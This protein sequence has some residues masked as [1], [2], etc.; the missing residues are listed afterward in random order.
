MALLFFDGFDM[1]QATSQLAHR[2]WTNLPSGVNQPG[3]FGTSRSIYMNGAANYVIRSLAATSTISIGVAFRCETM[4]GL[5]ATGSDVFRF[6]NGTTLQCKMGVKND[7]SL[8]IGRADFVGNLIAAS[9]VGLVTAASWNYVEVELTRDAAAGVMKVWFNGVLVIN[10]TG[11]NTGASDIDNFAFTGHPG[12]NFFYDDFYITNNATRLGERRVD[13][14]PPTADTATEDWSL[15]AGVNSYALLDEIPLNNDTDYVHSATVGNKD[16]FDMAD[17]TTTPVAIDGVQTVLVA[18]KDD[19]ATREVRTNLKNG[20]TTTN[21]TTRT[22]SAS[23][24][25]SSDLYLLNPDTAA[26]WTPA[27]INSTQLGIE[28]VT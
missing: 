27:E 18:R 5:V 28:V 9:A 14:L 17:L 13:Y 16:L 1:Y 10:S 25:I 20:T 24:A 15:S 19:A 2:G 12:N 21:G 22:M 26:A 23:Y 3:R 11:V 6:L 8:V 7:G 4:T